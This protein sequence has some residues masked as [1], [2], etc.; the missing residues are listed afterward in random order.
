MNSTEII[1]EQ[2]YQYRDNFLL[3][4]DS[5]LGTFWNNRETQH[6]RFEML[7]GHLLRTDMVSTIE[8]V[9]CG[10]CDM[11][12]YL[13]SKNLKFTY[14]GTEIISEMIAL[15][16]EK[17]PEITLLNRDIIKDKVTDKYDFVVLSGALNLPGST[18]RKEW[19]KFCYSLIQ[20]MFT[21]CNKAIAFNFLT[22]HS[23]FVDPALFYI[24][25]SEAVT[26]CL[27]DLSRF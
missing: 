18:D 6:L 21:M 15:A 16:K 27:S 7:T 5:P 25:P 22:T 8:D 4:K 11:Y 12:A 10:V 9:G 19:K 26:F 20:S 17:Y 24:N 2:I 14:S 13:K 1:R 23:T 3:H